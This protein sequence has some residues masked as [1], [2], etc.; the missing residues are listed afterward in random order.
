MCLHL[1]KIRNKYNGRYYY[2]PC[3][4]C[5][6]CL[7]KRADAFSRKLQ[8]T[9][10]DNALLYFVTLTYDSHY[11][12]FV[13]YSNLPF[14]RPLEQKD[15]N[16]K[17]CRYSDIR[18]NTAI[19]GSFPYSTLDKQVIGLKYIDNF[20]LCEN[21]YMSKIPFGCVNSKVDFSDK[22]AV[23][24]YKDIQNFIKRLR[25]K[26]T[27]LGY[28][29][30]GEYGEKYSRPHFHL[31]LYLPNY[32]SFN[33]IKNVICNVWLFGRVDV[34]LARD[35]SNY[36]TSYV[37]ANMLNLHPFL[38]KYFR[39]IQRSSMSLRSNSVF[40]IK[41]V[42]QNYLQGNFEISYNLLSGYL[43]SKEKEFFVPLYLLNYYFPNFRLY[44]Y[45]TPLDF[46]DL[47]LNSYYYDEQQLYK[48][49]GLNSVYFRYKY[50]IFDH[51]FVCSLSNT[52]Y[53]FRILSTELGICVLDY[54]IFAFDY[55][56][57]LKSYMLKKSY[58]E[59]GFETPFIVDFDAFNLLKY[60]DDVLD[61]IHFD[62]YK[63][64]INLKEKVKNL[65]YFEYSPIFETDIHLTNKYYQ[66]SKKHSISSNFYSIINKQN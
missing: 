27:L 23:L 37:S 45:I 60:R 10:F 51:P 35:I 13:H 25:N 14:N 33:L 22:L 46:Y 62:D 3:G 15:F 63:S 52:L 55:M 44:G 43:N 7:Q 32:Y 19:N 39:P 28:H 30:A 49:M 24:F 6:A 40:N 31:L 58:S 53:R 54:I 8:T 50:P 47:L 2:V 17:I 36:L 5:P 12:P 26:V 1:Q 65:D 29:V 59:Y 20:D 18:Y 66:K 56:R 64:L 57:K 48:N 61:F 41:N 38:L 21:S 42:Y 4:R 11:L 34:Q 16:L 9:K